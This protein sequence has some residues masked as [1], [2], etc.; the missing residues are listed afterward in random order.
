MITFRIL[1]AHLVVFSRTSKQY[2]VLFSLPYVRKAKCIMKCQCSGGGQ[3]SLGYLIG[4]Y[5][6]FGYLIE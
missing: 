3:S 2:R 5:V 6:Q 1:Y 4:N